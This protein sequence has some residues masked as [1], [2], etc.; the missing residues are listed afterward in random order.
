MKLCCLVNSTGC[1]KMMP[2]DDGYSFHI[3]VSS[4]YQDY[5]HDIMETIL[6]FIQKSIPGFVFGFSFTFK[7]TRGD[8]NSNS[9][10]GAVRGC[11]FLA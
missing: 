10:L 6:L 4:D 2:N 9:T 7:D 1:I 8:F 11:Y 5:D 3:K